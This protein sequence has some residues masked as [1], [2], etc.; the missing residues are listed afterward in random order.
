MLP[1]PDKYCICH[2][3]GFM[4]TSSATSVAISKQ[5]NRSNHATDDFGGM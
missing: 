1:F 4:K 3:C 5:K 2:V